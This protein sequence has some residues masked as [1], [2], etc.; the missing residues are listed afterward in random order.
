MVPCRKEAGLQDR[1]KGLFWRHLLAKF[2]Y[3][4]V[5]P[6]LCLSQDRATQVSS[7]LFTEGS[8][9]NAQLQTGIQQTDTGLTSSLG[10]V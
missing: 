8:L 6:A 2:W 10:F 1:A 5:A 9:I 7:R 4:L 3:C